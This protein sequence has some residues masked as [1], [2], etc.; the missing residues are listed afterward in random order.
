MAGFR[1][2]T[3]TGRSLNSLTHSLE[4]G[5]ETMV[6]LK[7]TNQIPAKWDET[8]RLR[9]TRSK[10]ESIADFVRCHHTTAEVVLSMHNGQ[11]SYGV[12]WTSDITT[13]DGQNLVETHLTFTF[14]ETK[15]ILGY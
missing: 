4:N 7:S 2:S 3:R 8:D 9:S 15:N 11:L 6:M 1:D 12:K 5:D 10:A 14:I 13:A